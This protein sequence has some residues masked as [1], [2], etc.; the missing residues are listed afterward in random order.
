[1]SIRNKLLLSYTVMLIL[2]IS[3]FVAAGLL[4]SSAITGDFKAITNIYTNQYALKP[5]T[6]Q[7]EN[8]FIDVKLIAKG[9]PEQLLEPQVQQ[10]AD[11][12][13]ALI[14]SGMLVRK[15]SDI[16]YMSESLKNAGLEASLPAHEPANINVRDT[17]RAGDRYF[18]Y[19]KFDFFFKDQTSGTI[20]T[21]KEV[22]PFAQLSRSLF[23]LWLVGLFV[24]LVGIYLVLYYFVTKS[25]IKPLHALRKGAEQITEGTL[26]FKMTSTKKDE[27]GELFLSFEEMRQRLKSS[28]DM[29]LQYEENRKELISNISHDLKT[30]ITTILGYVEGIR[31]GIADTPE[32]MDKYVK[33]IYYKASDMDRLIDELFLFSKLDLKRLPFT[34]EQVEISEYLTDCMDEIRF[35]LDQKGIQ[36]E[37]NVH[38]AKP[39]FV[40]AD[41]EQLKRTIMNI[42]D[43]SVKYMD[44]LDKSIKMDVT[45]ELEQVTI[46]IEDNGAG[47][48]EADLPYIFDRFYRADPSRNMDKRGSGL[49]LAIAKQIIREHGGDIRVTSQLHAGTRIIFTLKKQLVK[50][51]E[52]R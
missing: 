5:L 20:F 12:E 27:I 7:E 1:M 43:N 16:V 8:A 13:M 42:V 23:P 2:T 6:P 49:G 10:Q 29:Q 38:L 33:T 32:K 11:R 35:D 19:V 37:L 36:M 40:T 30:P 46:V 28:V 17:V 3:L 51:G 25:I 41:R 4:I 39:T 31:D 44:K 50:A 9:T 45:E 24:L 15:G 26:D 21:M 22:S 18:T 52:A 47:I 34:F 48:E 14:H